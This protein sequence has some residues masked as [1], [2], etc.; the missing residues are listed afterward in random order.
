MLHDPPNQPDQHVLLRVEL[1]A[2]DH[3]HLDGRQDEEPAEDV[4]HPGEVVDQ[5]GADSDRRERIGR[6]LER[7]HERIAV[8]GEKLGT[9]E[10]QATGK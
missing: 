5:L 2:R 3:R 7:I 6:I 8:L 1:P 4:D 10:A 9:P